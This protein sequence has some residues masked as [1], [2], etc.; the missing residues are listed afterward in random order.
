[1]SRRRL[2]QFSE[3]LQRALRE[4]GL[5]L[6]ASKSTLSPTTRIHQLGF[7]VDSA[8]CTFL[9]PHSKLREVHQA[10]L[11]LLVLASY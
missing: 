4:L 10:S 1:M 8:N 9:V 7:V 3:D 2:S 5:S 11:V 6:K